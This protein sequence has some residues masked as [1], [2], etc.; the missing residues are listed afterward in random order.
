MENTHLYSKNGSIACFLNKACLPSAQCSPVRPD[1]FKWHFL[2]SEVASTRE[3]LNA[4]DPA[5][6][7]SSRE[8]Q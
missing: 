5:N 2:L 6:E 8:A 4:R 1:W 7:P 3:E